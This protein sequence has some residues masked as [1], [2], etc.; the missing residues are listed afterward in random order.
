M[1]AL[2]AVPKVLKVIV[3]QNQGDAVD[4]E[5]VL[6]F[7]Y[8]GTAPNAAQALIFA[9]QVKQSWHDHIL[10]HQDQHLSLDKVEVI[11]LTSST[12]AQATTTTAPSAGSITTEA[13]TNG[14]A[15]IVSH[16]IDRRYRGGKPR[17]YIGGQAATNV[18]AAGEWGSAYLT[19]MATAWS[20]FLADVEGTVW[21]GG[22]S[23][24][25]VNVSFFSGFDNHTYPSGRTKAIPRV[26]ATPLVDPI[27]FPIL[28]AKV[29][30]Q[31]RRNAQ[32]R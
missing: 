18:T 5:N 24:G 20:L 29:G 17:T 14:A 16:Q 8:S 26:R 9:E 22:G 25:Q 12:S 23:I 27:T 31:R 28:R 3:T 1:P 10:I 21:S 13:V 4:I 6:H 15:L 2:P 11:D 19:T 7:S 30:S 32:S